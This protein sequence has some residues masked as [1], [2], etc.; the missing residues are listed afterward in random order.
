M[1]LTASKFFELLR[2]YQEYPVKL[3]S[4]QGEDF[5]IA[6]PV[7]KQEPNSLVTSCNKLRKSQ[8]KSEANRVL[9]DP[10]H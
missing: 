4:K 6:A 7:K 1:F 8:T 9:L 10:F 5:P 2:S 3:L